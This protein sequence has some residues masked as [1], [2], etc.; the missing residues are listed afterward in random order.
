MQYSKI[1]LIDLSCP[2]R[3]SFDSVDLNV[4]DFYYNF[5][6]SSKGYRLA[7]VSG[8]SSFYDLSRNQFGHASLS[9][10]TIDESPLIIAAFSVASIIGLVGSIL[11]INLIQV[12]FGMIQKKYSFWIIN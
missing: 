6:P 3:T 9:K 2:A 8:Y 5:F 11:L 7:M 1:I 4:R 12:S 10:I